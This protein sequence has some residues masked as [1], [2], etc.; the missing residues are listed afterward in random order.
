MFPSLDKEVI[1]D[2]V[3]AKQARFV[4][5]SYLNRIFLIQYQLIN[6]IR[7]GAAVD[8]CLNMTSL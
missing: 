7:I 5:F 6:T 8:A 3:I 2:I 4:L 1:S